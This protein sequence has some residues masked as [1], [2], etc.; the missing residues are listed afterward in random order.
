MAHQDPEPSSDR[1]VEWLNRNR[2]RVVALTG[3]ALALGGLIAAIHFDLFASSGTTT[4]TST[5]ASTLK[6]TASCSLDKSPRPGVTVELTYH[7]KA[8]RRARVGLGAGL[9]D[10]N[11]ND[12]STGQGDIDSLAIPAGASARTRIVPI[13]SKLPAGTYELDAEIWPPNQI[14]ADG[15]DTLTDPHC[16]YFKVG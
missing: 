15:K 11:G 5:V 9:Y 14:G 12:H 2:E 7:I 3:L 13:P 1:V 4:Q 8:S 16:A 6:I 10:N